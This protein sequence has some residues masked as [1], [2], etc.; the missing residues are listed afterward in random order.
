MIP[1]YV[2]LST[3]ELKSVRSCRA[4]QDYEMYCEGVQNIG[5]VVRKC[6]NRPFQSTLKTAT[7]TGITRN[8]YTKLWSY[9]FKEDD[10]AV[11]VF[12]CTLIEE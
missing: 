8:R 9:T 5:K 2:P 7:V 12:R 3:E 4:E 6:T 1:E 11:E 10:S